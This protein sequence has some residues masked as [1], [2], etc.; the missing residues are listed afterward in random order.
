MNSFDLEIRRAIHTYGDTSIDI[1][2]DY[3][4]EECLVQGKYWSKQPLIN[5]SVTNPYPISHI[6]SI[7]TIFSYQKEFPMLTIRTSR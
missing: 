2:V 3:S 1:V 5:V 6:G 7:E 4:R